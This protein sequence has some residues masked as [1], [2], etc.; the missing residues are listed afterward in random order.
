VNI[1]KDDAHG[2]SQI[3]LLNAP[4]IYAV[5]E[6]AAFIYLVKPVY[7]IGDGGLAGTG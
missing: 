2:A 4:D 1:L 3:L 5:K 7:E 6:Y